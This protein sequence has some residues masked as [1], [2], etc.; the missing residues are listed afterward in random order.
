MKIIPDSA[1]PPTLARDL[2]EAEDRVLRE[3]KSLDVEALQ[4]AYR[5]A[6]WR[7]WHGVEPRPFKSLPEHLRRR[8]GPGRYAAILN[9]LEAMVTSLAAEPAM[10]YEPPVVPHVHREPSPWR[11]LTRRLEMHAET[12]EIRRRDSDSF[13]SETA[14]EAEERERLRRVEVYTGRWAEVEKRFGPKVDLSNCKKGPAPRAV[15]D[16]TSGLPHRSLKRAAESAGLNPG[17]LRKAL[18]RVP[19]GQVVQFAGRD[20]KYEAPLA[21]GAKTANLAVTAA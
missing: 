14:R 18:N 1:L 20:W 7:A 19:V 17:E 10:A 16:L 9:R 11:P 5:H 21:E 8:V 15:L 4:T 6:C 3:I 13:E 2:R 12:C